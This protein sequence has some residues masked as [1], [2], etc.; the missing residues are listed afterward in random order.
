MKKEF[1]SQIN[2]LEKLKL[3]HITIPKSILQTHILDGESLYN[4]RFH[5]TVNNKISWRSGTMP[6]GDESAYI[7]ISKARMKDLDVS[8]GDSISIN[9]E[10]DTSEFGMEVPIEFEELLRQ[11][12]FG[13]EKFKQLTK[14]KQRALLYLILQIKSSE[15]RIEKSIFFLENI[16]K[17]TTN[18][19]SMRQ[20]LGKE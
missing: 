8:L 17:T 10:K 13:L 5:V 19:I 2:K 14:G 9:L 1:I 3:F 15:K 16:K 7:T 11:D 12:E 6:L 4:Q 18:K 20:I